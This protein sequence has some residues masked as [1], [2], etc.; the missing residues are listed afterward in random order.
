MF[1]WFKKGDQLLRYESR[2]LASDAYELTIRLADG[3][4]RS[5]RFTDPAALH[6]RQ[7]LLEEELNREGWTGPHGWNV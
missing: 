2:R 5:E 1:W 4:E 3:S 7:L 6:D